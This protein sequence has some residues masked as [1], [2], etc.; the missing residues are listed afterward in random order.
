MVGMHSHLAQL[1]V[2]ML[3]A[4]TL[5]GVAQAQAPAACPAVLDHRLPRLQDEVPQDLCQFK[6]KV[7]LIVNTASYCGFTPQYEGL[8]KLYATYSARGFAVLGFPS[9]DFLFQEP[10]SNQEIAEFCFNTYGVKFPMFGKSSVTGKSANPVFAVLTRQ[11]GQ[12]PKWNFHKYLVDREG[13]VVANF[14]S[15]ITPTDPQIT[16]RIE[17]LLSAP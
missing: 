1:L 16:S 11:S 13:R 7:L 5:T 3:A 14:K 4:I 12:A 9:N 10:K 2:A 17:Q 8:E 6:G 15:S